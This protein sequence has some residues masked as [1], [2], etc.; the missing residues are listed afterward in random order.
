M[1]IRTN[2]EIHR[3]ANKVVDY[4]ELPEI[5]NLLSALLQKEYWIDTDLFTKHQELCDGGNSC[6]NTKQ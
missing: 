5:K 3:V 2:E 6:T 1:K 4:I